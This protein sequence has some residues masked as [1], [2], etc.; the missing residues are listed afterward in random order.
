MK[1]TIAITCAVLAAFGLALGGWWL[2]PHAGVNHLPQPRTV[3]EMEPESS[4]EWIQIRSFNADNVLLKSEVYYRNGETGTRI[5]RANK[6]LAR[7]NIR[8]ADGHE[9]MWAEYAADGVQIV[10]GREVRSDGSTRWEAAVDASEMVTTTTYWYNGKVFSTERRKVG[11]TRAERWFY[12]VSGAKWEHF[13]GT[14]DGGDLTEIEEIWHEDGSMQFAHYNG[15]SGGSIDSVYRAD[16]TLAL[17][18]VWELRP[19]YYSEENTPALQ[20]RVLSKVEVYS[21]DGNTLE[22]EYVMASGGY[23]VDR[24]L[25][26]N[27]DGTVW[28]HDLMYDGSVSVS[29]K[30][31]AAGNVVERKGYNAKTTWRVSMPSELRGNFLDT[32]DAR[33]TW[34]DL[35]DHPEKR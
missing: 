18:Q 29:L 9:R 12:Y 30:R 16:G 20:R 31:D 13:V 28:D 19:K 4:N 23:Y 32:L 24:M 33:I 17:R 35:E 25:E 14:T 11:K 2:W 1:K 7:E 15:M 6:T 26:H 27:A 8:F 21:A 10:K 34:R 5:W 3:I 22:R